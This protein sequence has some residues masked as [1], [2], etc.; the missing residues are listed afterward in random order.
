MV[1]AGCCS[2][3][4]AKATEKNGAS[5]VD[6]AP[7]RAGGWP[8]GPRVTAATAEVVLLVAVLLQAAMAR[9]VIAA[10]AAWRAGRLCGWRLTRVLLC[11]EDA[12]RVSG[13][14]WL[15]PRPGFRSGRRP[16]G[17]PAAGCRTGPG[18]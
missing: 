9:R 17:C 1:T 3:Y 15:G 12:E 2:W 11:A 13:A 8:P 18:H 14:G 4:F 10:A 6:P 16:R 7:V 5:N